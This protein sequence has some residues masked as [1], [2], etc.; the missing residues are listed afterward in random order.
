MAVLWKVL[1]PQ[2]GQH[3]CI[4]EHPG[5]R[6]GSGEHAGLPGVRVVKCFVAL[7]PA[8]RNAASRGKVNI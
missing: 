5:C 7:S 8:R 6:T 4:P 2:K 1:V 3:R